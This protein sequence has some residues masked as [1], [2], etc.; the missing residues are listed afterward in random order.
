MVWSN[1]TKAMKNRVN[2]LR[3]LSPATSHAHI[4]DSFLQQPFAHG[5]LSEQPLLLT[6]VGI[7]W[8]IPAPLVRWKNPAAKQLNIHHFKGLPLLLL[9]SRMWPLHINLFLK[10]KKSQFL[11]RA[12][13]FRGYRGRKRSAPPN[14]KSYKMLKLINIYTNKFGRKTVLKK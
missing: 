4:T 1:L 14:T 10:K 3:I 9:I 8:C 2:Q 7:A 11:L 13:R 6:R 12:G 5:I